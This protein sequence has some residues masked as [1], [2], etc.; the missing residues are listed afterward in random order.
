MSEPLF[1]L[2]KGAP[3]VSPVSSC[4]PNVVFFLA[5]ALQLPLPQHLQSV[6]AS[7]GAPALYNPLWAPAHQT[8]KK[9]Q[10]WK[11]EVQGSVGGQ[12]LLG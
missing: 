9:T 12:L 7:R 8:P 2:N 5:K 11:D 6:R 4:L 10:V 1:M 3:G